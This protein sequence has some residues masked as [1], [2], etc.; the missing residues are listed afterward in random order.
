MDT[1]TLTMEADAQEGG[2]MVTDGLIYPTQKF[3]SI[4]VFNRRNYGVFQHLLRAMPSEIQ[5][6]CSILMARSRAFT[7]LPQSNLNLNYFLHGGGIFLRVPSVIAV[8]FK[9]KSIR[10][11]SPIGAGSLHQAA[12]VW[13]GLLDIYL[14]SF[15]TPSCAIYL[16]KSRTQLLCHMDPFGL[17][18]PVF[19]IGQH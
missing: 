3:S 9:A 10:L 19:I 17:C 16:H 15:V 6:S 14:L 18:D 13:R 7:H 5:V 12:L 8:C 1:G 2:T 11:N 4:Q